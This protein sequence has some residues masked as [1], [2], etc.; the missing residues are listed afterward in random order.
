M[1][2]NSLQIPIDADP[3]AHTDQL[4]V[5]PAPRPHFTNQTEQQQRNTSTKRARLPNK[6]HHKLCSQGDVNP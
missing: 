2:P 4:E 5:I 1:A 3:P 6:T